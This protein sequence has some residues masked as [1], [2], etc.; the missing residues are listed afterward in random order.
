MRTQ[1][2]SP[3][4]KNIS[5][6]QG[7]GPKLEKLFLKLVGNKIV[8]LLKTKKSLSSFRKKKLNYLKI[9]YSLEVQV[10]KKVIFG[11]VV[12]VDKPIFEMLLHKDK[13]I[14]LKL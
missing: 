11:L 2:L 12:L 1:N 4:F 10:N 6:I 9:K 14:K 3:L 7:I 8:N 5:S 13:K